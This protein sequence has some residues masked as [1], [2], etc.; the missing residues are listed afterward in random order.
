M[1]PIWT[2]I[3]M[4]VASNDVREAEDTLELVDVLGRNLRNWNFS[5][6]TQIRVPVDIS[7]QEGGMYFVVLRMENGSLKTQKVTVSK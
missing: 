2:Q 7:E 4:S 5:N 1:N 3:I 6:E